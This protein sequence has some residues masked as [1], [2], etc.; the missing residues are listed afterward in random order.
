MAGQGRSRATFTTHE[1]LELVTD[2]L[3][4]A[5][6]GLPYSQM[7]EAT[8]GD[9]TYF[10]SVIGGALP[11]G[12]SLSDDG[13]ITGTPTVE[14]VFTFNVVVL[15]GEQAVTAELS[16]DVSITPAIDVEKATNG[17]DADEPTGPILSVGDPVSWT[18]VVTNTGNAPLSDV[19]VTDDQGVVVSCPATSLG[20]GE[21]M[22]CTATGTAVA[23]QYAN[24]ATAS[25]TAPSGAS[26]SDEDP[27]HYFAEVAS[28]DLEKTTNN[29]DADDPP[30]RF[31]LV[32]EVVQWRYIVT[33]TGNAPLTGVVVTDDQG[34]VVSCPGPNL[35]PGASMTCTAA[36]S[37]ATAGPYANVGTVTGTTPSGSTVTDADSSHY[38]GATKSIGVEKATNGEDADVPTGP[39][40]PVG[41]PVSWAYVVTNTGDTELT[42]VVV[43]DD[44]GVV[45]S[46]P[47]TDLAP[48]ESMT[49]TATGTAVAGQYANIVT[50][51]GTLV[52]GATVS[53]TDP[54]HYFGTAPAIAVE[55]ATNLQDAD[56][57]TGPFVPVGDPV[58][59]TY[60]VTNTGNADLT[61]VVVTD[62][63]GVVVSCPQTDLGPGEF[64]TCTAS[65]TAVT[66]QYA[67]V[68]T[69]TGT[70]PSGA[71]V[72]A[73][74]PSHYFGEAPSII[75]EKHTNGRDADAAPGVIVMAGAVVSWTYIV[76]NTGNAPLTAMTCTAS[77]IAQV[78]Q[79][80]NLG[81]ASGTA[82]S[83]A[84]VQDS[85]PSHYVGF[86]PGPAIIFQKLTNG[87]DADA[88][89]GP[90]IEVGADVTWS[91][92]I[93]NTGDV[94]FDVVA[95]EDPP[96]FT[97]IVLKD[98][99]L[100][101]DNIGCPINESDPDAPM[102]PVGATIICEARGTATLGQYSNT[103]T[104]DVWDLSGVVPVLDFTETDDSHYIG[105]APENPDIDIEKSTNGSDADT[106]SGPAIAVGALVSWTYVV[107]NTGDV[108]LSSVAVSDDKGVAVSCPKTTLNP[109]EMMTCT[110]S[111]TATAGLYANVGT[112]SGLS[113]QN[114]PVTDSD[115]SHYIGQAAGAEITIEKATDGQDADQ[116]PGPSLVE[117]TTVTWTYVVANTGS[118]ALT[119][120]AVVDDQGVA[121]SCPQT[122]L[123]VGESITC[124]ASSASGPVSDTDPSHYTGEG[125][126]PAPA[127]SIEKATNGSDADIAPGPSLAE[128]SA[129][130]W[131]YVV[132][133]T[134]NVALSSVGVVDSKGVFVSCP[135]DYLAPTESMT[136][137]ASGTAGVGHYSNLGTASGQT[138][139]G[140]PISASDPSY[141]L[142]LLMQPG[143]S[144]EKSTDGQDADAAPG[145]T[146]LEGAPVTWTYVVV[147]I[148]DEDLTSVAVADDQLGAVTCPQST[149][150]VGESMTCTETGTVALGQYSNVATATASSSSGPV[151][152]TD[153]SHYVGVVSNPGISVEKSTEGQDADAAPGPSLVEGATV[154]WTYV[155]TN[156]GNAPLTS[157]AL[158]DDV[159]GAVMCPKSTLAVGESMTCTETGTVALGQYSNVAT[160][161]ASSLTGP[162]SDTDPSHYFGAALEPGP[163]VDI[164]KSTNGQ[165]ADLAPGPALVVG[166]TVTWTYVV[167]NTG[168]EALTDV[169][170]TDTEESPEP[171][172]MPVGCPQTTLA[173]GE[174]M[175]CTFNGGTATLGQYSNVGDVTAT[176]ASGPVGD[177]DTSHYVGEGASPS[178]SIDI[179]KY[180]NGQNADTDG[181][182]IT[183]GD[184]VNWTYEVRNTGNVLLTSV[185][186]TDDDPSGLGIVVVCPKD[187]LAPGEEIGEMMT[188]E[189]LVVDPDSESVELIP[190]TAVDGSYTN[191]GTATGSSTDGPVSDTD[192]SGY[193][194]GAG[195]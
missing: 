29:D 176:A 118:E 166:T 66:G 81:S 21:S 145:P 187:F 154:T 92:V 170:V 85:D 131:T 126:S 31:I 53:D 144:V 146:L 32:G 108:T 109:G 173:V 140:Q 147:N 1:T 77:G 111:G 110:A 35:A 188:C 47:K 52:G 149:L 121:V 100:A 30:G 45:V 127:I 157:V 124:T 103:G 167:T 63:Q 93:T 96:L 23:G 70:E 48:G 142:G 49:C 89:T 24:V 17:E 113:P 184:D 107:T 73:T 18:Y 61:G 27:S 123:A 98:S 74:D 183:V 164:E 51:S 38:F 139:S 159:E 58:S 132:T 64:M 194:G 10:W 69:A 181:P 180:T 79:Y 137:T 57:P 116:A 62:D 44:Q 33:N 20:H 99:D 97:D 152:D 161:T 189:G 39:L 65:G 148:G 169:A 59:W 34:L 186:V 94:D 151:S 50:A 9:G 60:V 14:G 37:T 178:A 3:P 6:P 71:T 40:V 155:V 67:N 8:G 72:N 158:S 130:T 86:V 26:V 42:N 106:P 105:V 22:T 90:E 143:I 185:V 82:P 133:N 56:V 12:L 91:Y 46:C 5:P 25:G 115:P 162:V 4:D 41:D 172:P 84:V 192:P 134:G 190:A 19:V 179:E 114:R 129:V 83:G 117:G 135:A 191:L 177:S 174:S 120:V 156:T 128:G 16:I 122:T 112:A 182:F 171:D 55:K 150:A 125:A 87:V 76:T 36:P 43:T 102:L 68:G 75:V 13:A 141:Y 88:P 54:S 153:P 78:G 80:S 160:A 195:E 101:L 163:A 15:S 165:D 7:L 193:T 119:G 136:C 175:T 168:D 28:I 95:E 104:A 2:E 11:D 138:S